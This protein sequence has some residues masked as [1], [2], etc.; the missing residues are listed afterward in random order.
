MCAALPRPSAQIGPA[1]PMQRILAE[2]RECEFFEF[3]NT[4]SP[5]QTWSGADTRRCSNVIDRIHQLRLSQKGGHWSRSQR[6]SKKPRR[7]ADNPAGC[8]S[9]KLDR[10][11][12]H[13]ALPHDELLRPQKTVRLLKHYATNL[14]CMISPPACR[15]SRGP[16][17]ERSD[18][19]TSL[20]V[21]EQFRY[22]GDIFG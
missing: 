18:K 6:G 17:L 1:F 9:V 19:G 5:E 16:A 21:S 7:V 22:R 15:C 14:N 20:R 10:L 13:H 12:K 11:A 3:F 2:K 4:I 8:N